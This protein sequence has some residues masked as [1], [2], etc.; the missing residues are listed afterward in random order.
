MLFFTSDE[1]YGHKRIIEYCNRPFDH[2]SQMDEEIIKRHNVIV[3]GGD[4]VV[5]VGD[6]T[7]LPTLEE[8]KKYIS[9]LNGHHIFLKGSHDRWLTSNNT[10]YEKKVNGQVIVA[11][12]YAMRVW[13][14]SHYG[15]WHVYGHSHGK[16]EPIGKSWDVGVD[17]NNFFPVSFDQLKAIM[18]HRPD[19]LN[20]VR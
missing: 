11:C 7:L 3:S 17:K 14:K 15:S 9:R 12:H 13:A 5:H 6:F 1:H 20:M 19:N 10:I 16:L 8:A 4:T 18:L 2:L